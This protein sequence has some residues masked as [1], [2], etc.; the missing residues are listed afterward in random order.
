MP[1]RF[2]VSA[3]G[4][5]VPASDSAPINPAAASRAADPMLSSRSASFFC[6]SSTLLVQPDGRQVLIEEVTWADL[7]AFDIGA[8]RHATVPEG[9]R[10]FVR[11]GVDHVSLELAH[12]RPLLHRVGLVQHLVVYLDFPLVFVAAVILGEYR[13]R[14]VLSDNPQSIDGALL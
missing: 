8:V 2:G 14:Q 10:Q 3:A 4:A 9:Q 5:A 7:P 6:L 1:P 12:Q 13:V 11:L